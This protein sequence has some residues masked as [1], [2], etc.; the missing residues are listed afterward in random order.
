MKREFCGACVQ[1]HVMQARA[2]SLESRKGYPVHRS[3]AQGHLAEAEDEALERMPETALIIR[4]ER[5]KM[6]KDLNYMPDWEALAVLVGTD[7]ML[8][9]YDGGIP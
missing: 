9:G 3:F 7:A 6:E 1:K 2:L 4:E 5:L 8:P